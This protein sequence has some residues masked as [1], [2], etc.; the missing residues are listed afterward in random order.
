LYLFNTCVRAA[1]S[2]SPE[3]AGKR[4]SAASSRMIVAVIVSLSEVPES[5]KEPC[6]GR[7]EPVACTSCRN[8]GPPNNQAISCMA[9]VWLP[10]RTT[11][12]MT[13]FSENL[14]VT[15]ETMAG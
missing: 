15:L 12:A 10:E 1:S 14:F 8:I 9:W 11:F 5:R 7:V 3:I 6:V 2:A 13:F 4:L